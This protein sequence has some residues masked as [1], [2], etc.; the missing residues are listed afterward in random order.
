[1]EPTALDWIERFALHLRHER[2]LS[3]HT[4]DAYLRDLRHLVEFCDGQGIVAWPALTIHQIRGYVSW[5]HRKGIGGRS[6]QRELSA[7]RGL[8]NFLLREG[9]AELNPALDVPA[10]KTPRHLPDTLDVDQTAR[11][12]EIKGD[13]DDTLR[14]RAIMER[15]RD[16]V[17]ALIRKE[18]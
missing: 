15:V 2:R 13:D 6:L 17:L 16:D 9:A 1:M 14:D 10:P 3:P 8:F 11:L 12:V 18:G 4:L 5:R 7:I